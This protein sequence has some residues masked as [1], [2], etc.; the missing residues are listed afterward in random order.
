[1]ALIIERYLTDIGWAPSTASLPAWSPEPA[2]SWAADGLHLA[3]RGRAELAAEPTRTRWGGGV[4]ARVSFGSLEAVLQLS[5]TTPES[6]VVRYQDD[7]RGR[8][9]AFGL[10]AVLSGGACWHLSSRVFCIDAGA[11][12]EMVRGSIRGLYLYRETKT[13]AWQP[14]L[15]FELRFEQMI[16]RALGLSL[17][18]VVDARPSQAGFEVK[19]ATSD[20][21]TPVWAAAMQVGLWWIVF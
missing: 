4:A 21:R 11:G 7:R 15:R 14:L 3:L 17:A 13:T 10:D 8:I 12:A 16:G 18:T 9:W 20:Y 2:S 5:G 19:G 6:R 1:M